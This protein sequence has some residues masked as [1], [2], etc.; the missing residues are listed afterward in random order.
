MLFSPAVVIGSG[1][2]QAR[3]NGPGRISTPLHNR[4][5]A[6]GGQMPDARDAVTIT[7]HRT[8]QSYE[9]LLETFRR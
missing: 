2:P 7:D 4:S 1:P 6:A 8:G 3:P 5:Q 9:L